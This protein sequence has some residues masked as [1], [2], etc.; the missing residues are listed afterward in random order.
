MHCCRPLALLL[1]P[2]LLLALAARDAQAAEDFPP[3]G[4]TVHSSDWSESLLFSTPQVESLE[5]TSFD[6]QP[7][8]GG[9]LGAVILQRA[10]PVST[11]FVINPVTQ[12]N[13]IDPAN[14]DFPFQGGFDVGAVRYGSWADVE[15]RYFGV[16]DWDAMQGPVDSPDGFGLPIPGFDPSFFPLTIA[17][18]YASSLNSVELNLRRSIRPR[19][20]LL[21]G[22]RY[23][24]MRERLSFFVGDQALEN[25]T[26]IGFNANNDLFG[27]QIG[28][29]G[30]LWRP[31]A[32]FRVE[33]ALKAGVYVDA[34]RS[35]IGA[36][37]IGA[38]GGGDPDV[39][40][41]WGHDHTAFVGDLSFAAV[42]QITDHLAL[43]GGY[44]LLWLSGVAV[45][46][47]QIHRLNLADGDVGTNTSH[48]TFYHGALVGLEGTW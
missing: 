47:E 37:H 23:V 1:A 9:Y 10:R 15:F 2:V 26:I 42:F 6:F 39:I 38:G 8:W 43:R 46:S 29:E 11:P 25:G 19:L 27:L 12:Q 28:G 33:S 16:N 20:A 44:Q 40:T 14:F 35:S 4:R 17:S 3:L 5:W 31:T 21:A 36:N 18:W 13:I 7:R 45:A 34:A 48:G 22:L 32:R 41:W 30:I 24:S